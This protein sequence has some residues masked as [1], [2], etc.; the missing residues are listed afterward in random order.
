MSRPPG[1]RFDGYI[2]VSR[3]GKRKGPSFISPVVQREA[4][5]EWAERSG[6]ELLHVY[7]EFDESGSRADR[8]LLAA[9]IER[10]EREISDGLVVW[11]V[12]RFGRSLLDGL[13]HIERIRGS[14]GRFCA[15]GD[16]L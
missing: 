1:P 11:R 3:V 15:V 4:I 9:A 7:E 5:E 6:V 13:Q 2:R 12:D 16:G 10:V 14:G 8:P